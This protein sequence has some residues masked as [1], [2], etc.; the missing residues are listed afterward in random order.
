V[1]GGSPTLRRRRLGHALRDLREQAGL[2]GDQAGAVV[3]RSGSWVS[4]VESGRVGLRV[5]ELRDLLARY[6]VDDL[7]RRQELEELAV[8]GKQR[9]W[10]S[11]Y[12]DV[13]AEQYL[14]YIGLEAEARSILIY[15][16][17]LVPGLF[18]TEDYCRAIYGQAVPP[19][20]AEVFEA[21]VKVR[22]NRQ[23]ILTADEPPQLRV[24]LD[25]RVLYRAVGGT[26]VLKDQMTHLGE[27]AHK[28]FVDLRI[29]PLAYG[30]E[31]VTASS[32]H[33]MTFLK[34]PSVVYVET[35]S[36]GVVVDSEQDVGVH[37]KI[38]EHLSAVASERATT[39]GDLLEKA[40]ERLR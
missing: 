11:K 23:R 6:G 5:R 4:R 26:E 37:S 13:L 35:F 1:E 39:A 25:E 32:F 30:D 36:G 22:M 27:M 34:D 2:T 17:R 33:V 29:L 20:S 7:Q 18:Q 21:R 40:L 28:P 24:V 12:A 8:E 14:T 31:F 19:L 10:W 16:D 15:E 3:E 38:F 9:G